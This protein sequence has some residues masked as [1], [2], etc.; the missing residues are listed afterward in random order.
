ML[1]LRN[2]FALILCTGALVGCGQT[3]P[4]Y[5]PQQPAA[6]RATTRMPPAASS[7]P[8]PAPALPVPAPATRQA[9]A[10]AAP[11]SQSSAPPPRIRR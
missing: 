2:T 11:A 7:V 10:A 8:A 9:P 6:P 5:L 1:A 4:L 3:G